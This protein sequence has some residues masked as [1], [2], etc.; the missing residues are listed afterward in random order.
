MQRLIRFSERIFYL[1]TDETV[2]RPL[3]MAV[4]GDERT[5]IIDGGN[6]ANHARAF[7]EVLE[8]VGVRGDILVLTH[9]HWDHV[10]GV[11]EFLLPTIAHEKTKDKLDVLRTFEWTD[12]AL[13][14]RLARGLTTAFS[15]GNIQR[16]FKDHRNVEVASPDMTFSSRVTLELGGVR[17]IIEHVGGDHADDS[18]II[19]IPEEHV[20]FLGDCLYACIVPGG[21]YY[22]AQGTLT[23]V[24]KLESYDAAHYFLSHSDEP[25]T[26]EQWRHELELLRL[27]AYGVQQGLA[28]VDE[29]ESSLTAVWNRPLSDDERETIAFFVNGLSVPVVKT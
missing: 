13:E 14:D 1:T 11:A 4:V 6:S 23:L 27:T 8:Q 29:L 15:V 24:E 3:L 18:T 10:F 9:A 7:R 5:L 17:A 26:L 21:W 28:S 25:L 12:A 19:H 20:V 2:D 16:E 22:T